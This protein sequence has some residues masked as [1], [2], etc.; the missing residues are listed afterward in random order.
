MAPSLGAWARSASFRVWADDWVLA[1][2]VDAVFTL[3]V[4]SKDHK[5][6]FFLHVSVSPTMGVVSHSLFTSTGEARGSLGHDRILVSNTSGSWVTGVHVKLSA[7]NSSGKVIA[8]LIW[9]SDLEGMSRPGVL[10][11]RNWVI[12][13]VRKGEFHIWR[14]AGSRLLGP[15]LVS[16]GMNSGTLRLSLP[17]GDVAMV[18]PENF[19]GEVMFIDLE[20]TF[21]RGSLVEKS[22]R[23][24]CNDT[25]PTEVVSMPDGSVSTIHLDMSTNTYYLV[26]SVTHERHTFPEV[27]HVTAIDQRHVYVA[28]W[29][30]MTNYQVCC[31]GLVCSTAQPKGDVTEVKFEVRDGVTGFLL[32]VFPVPIRPPFL[33]TNS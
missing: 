1:P 32:G 15:K 2:A 33:F 31:S 23:V 18:F 4:E 16:T 29:L 21:K 20:S 27:H 7:V 28:P 19:E 9:E 10:C 11:N 8:P 25:W 17:N 26:N 30:R 5:V 3:P 12:S 22:P 6:R 14:V 24:A 13:V